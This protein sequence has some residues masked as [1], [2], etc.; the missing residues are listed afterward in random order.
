MALD[1]LLNEHEQSEKLRAWLRK[2]GPSL[3][4]GLAVVVAV[5]GGWNWWTQHSHQQKLATGDAYQS[6]RAALAAG[7]MDTAARVAVDLHDGA[8][9]ELIALDLAKAQVDA[10]K[11]D[12]AI[13]SLRRAETG[14]PALQRIIQQRLARL[15][16]ASSQSEQALALLADGDDA[17]TLE[18]RGD[19]YFALNQPDA[20]RQAYLDALR[21]LDVAAPQRGLVEYKLVQVG[22]TPE[23]RDQGVS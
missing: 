9:A 11:L 21:R 10:G 19:A 1:E 20:A 12:D 6:V 22:G 16:I 23:Q 2:R 5:I 13:A 14:N 18:I 3:I 8:Y 15:L 17:A 7:D 4:T